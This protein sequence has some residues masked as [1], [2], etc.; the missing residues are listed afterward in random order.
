MCYFFSKLT[1]IRIYQRIFVKF[2]CMKFHKIPFN[3][4][5]AS[6]CRKTDSRRACGWKDRHKKANRALLKYFGKLGSR[7]AN[8]SVCITLPIFAK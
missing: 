8:G 2:P 5:H 6:P 3:G 4:S 7:L 1:E